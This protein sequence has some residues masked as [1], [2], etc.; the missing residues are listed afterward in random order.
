MHIIL[1]DEFYVPVMA[2][3][4]V[5]VTAMIPYGSEVSVLA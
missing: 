4:I 2:F 3:S 5:A 1:C